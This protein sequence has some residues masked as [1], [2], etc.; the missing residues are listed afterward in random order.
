FFPNV[1]K[2]WTPIG[3]TPILKEPLKRK[4]HS[5]IGSLILSPTHRRIRFD[6]HLQTES[7][8]FDDLNGKNSK[9]ADFVS[10]KTED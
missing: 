7:V 9:L 4:H 10:E 8:K 2:T 1:C 6:F 5:A 3:Q